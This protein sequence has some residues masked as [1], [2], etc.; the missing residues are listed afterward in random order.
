MRIAYADTEISEGPRHPRDTRRREPS[1]SADVARALLASG[2]F[3]KTDPRAVSGWAKQL[4]AVRFPAG[5]AMVQDGNFGNRLHVIIAGRV[6]VC[7]RRARGCEFVLN[8]LGPSDILGAIT[9][10]SAGAEYLTATTLTEVVTVPIERDQFCGWM[11]EHPEVACQMLR[12]LARWTKTTTDCLVDFVSEDV[13][14]R[15]ASRLL[16]LRKRFGLQE[17][18]AVRVV[19]NLTPEDFSLLVG[20]PRETVGQTLHEFEERGWIRLED[21]SLVIVDAQALMSVRPWSESEVC[22]A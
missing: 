14:V 2:I 11:T 19:H 13:Q 5:Y 12:L 4:A 20:I 17:G 6:K 9:F 15:L 1:Q 3:S 22:G 10:F 21:N 8:I 16:F 7:H 18:D